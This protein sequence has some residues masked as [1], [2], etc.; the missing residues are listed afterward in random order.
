[1][2]RTKIGV[3][4][5]ALAFLALYF[6]NPPTNVQAQALKSLKVGYIPIGDFLPLYMAIEKGFFAAQ[7]LKVE[8]TPMAGG[9]AIMP[10]IAG[11]S[12]DLGISA[13]HSL[14]MAREQGFEF[15]MVADSSHIA[16]KDNAL[17]VRKDSNIKSYKDL[18]GK[19]VAI[20]LLRAIGHI[21]IKEMIERQGGDIKKVQFVEI[22]FPRMEAPLLNREVDAVH[23]P[24]PFVTVLAANPELTIIGYHFYEVNPGGVVAQFISS[25]RWI[26]AN[27]DLAAKFT[28]AI[29]R[30]IDYT[31]ANEAEA[32]AVLAKYTNISPDL[33]KKVNLP[34]YRR[35]LDVKNLQW[36]I[37]FML[38]HGFIKKRLNAEDMVHDTAR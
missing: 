15:K 19:K 35:N 24:E 32:R 22:P 30:A 13:A 25:E 18:E 5:T 28:E 26:K 36:T 21:Y 33:A 27:P 1:M 31:N 6:G 4:F 7:G 14:I 12:L 11:G 2:R 3:I 16:P 20:N 17:V 38:K 8:L 10:A 29:K 23:I 9:A 34:G 37:D